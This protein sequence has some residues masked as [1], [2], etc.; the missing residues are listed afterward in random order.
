M[1]LCKNAGMLVAVAVIAGAVSGGMVLLVPTMGPLIA[2]SD[3][4]D[5]PSAINHQGVILVNGTRYSGSAQLKFA[6]LDPDSGTNVWSSSADANSDGI[7]DSAVTLTVADGV[8]SVRLGAS[9]MNALPAGIF[10]D[11]NLKLR[12]WFDDGTH[13]FQELSPN[14]ELTSVPYAMSVADGAISSAKLSADAVTTAKVQD[15]AITAAK[16]AANVAVVPV[17][18]VV[19]TAVSSAPAGWL[20]C[21]GAAVSRETYAA[22]FAAIG[23]TFGSGNGSTT[24]NLPNLKGRVPAGLDAGQSEFNTRGKTGGA[25]THTL[26]KAE[27]PSHNHGINDPGHGHGSNA[28]FTIGGIGGSGGSGIPNGA[29]SWGNPTYGNAH[30]YSIVGNTTGISIQSNGSGSAHNNLQP[31]MA[32]NYIIKH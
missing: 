32:L 24:F 6:I 29:S 3:V 25:K 23:T 13:G 30:W 4:S 10:A 26:S 14:Q 17:G 7:P 12:V 31:Y 18:T 15:G 1:S 2:M 5:V 11:G 19:S 27:M 22:L 21:D 8:Y 16:L 20:L 9:P 28:A